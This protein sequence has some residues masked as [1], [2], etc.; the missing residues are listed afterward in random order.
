MSNG[1][2]QGQILGVS[3]EHLLVGGCQ[4][5]KTYRFNIAQQRY[6]HQQGAYGGKG[7]NVIRSGPARAGGQE[8]EKKEVRAEEGRMSE[9]DKQVGRACQIYNLCSHWWWSAQGQLVFKRDA[10][11]AAPDGH[12]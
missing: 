7:L 4:E 9:P 2:H 3:I 5:R 11:I 12:R 8:R 10:I 1:L 6:F